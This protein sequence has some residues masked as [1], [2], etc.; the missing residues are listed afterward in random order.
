LVR[1]L[2]VE[3][4]LEG[5]GPVNLKGIHWVI[6]GG[7]S[8]HGA[9]PL[10]REW[11]TSIRDQCSDTGVPFFFKQWGGVQKKRAGR[12]LDGQTYDGF[13]ARISQPASP[14]ATAM[15]WAREIQEEYAGTRGELL[16]VL[17]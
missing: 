17:A 7:E 4:L 8:G 9:R 12:E 3:P 1:F 15:Q 5:L 2:S 11:V 10:K 14:I 13:P 6:V 16:P